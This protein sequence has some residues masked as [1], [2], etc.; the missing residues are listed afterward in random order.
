VEETPLQSLQT[1]KA[2]GLSKLWAQDKRQA[3]FFCAAR[4]KSFDRP[5][6]YIYRPKNNRTFLFLNDLTNKDSCTTHLNPYCQ[7]DKN[8]A[9]Q[10]S[11]SAPF[12]QRGYNCTLQ[13][14]FGGLAQ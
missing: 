13:T 6:K 4:H 2:T 5:I 14:W 11:R 12:R 1:S 3:S 9:R 10:H 7:K 8:A